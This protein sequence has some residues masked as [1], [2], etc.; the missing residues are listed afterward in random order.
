MA[1]I[2]NTYNSLDVNY[3]WQNL[4]QQISNLVITCIQSF[5]NILRWEEIGKTSREFV[6]I[7]KSHKP[8]LSQCPWA[9][10][11]RVQDWQLCSVSSWT[12][13]GFCFC[14]SC[15][16]VTVFPWRRIINHSSFSPELLLN[17][18]L[19]LMEVM[20]LLMIRFWSEGW[21]EF[22]YWLFSFDIPGIPIY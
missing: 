22:G 3:V 4:T 13:K 14:R 21:W 9:R 7:S 19:Q 18:N 15:R 2:S 8:P 16:P 20:Q 6:K 5:T 17:W 1:P 11:R 12:I 10:H